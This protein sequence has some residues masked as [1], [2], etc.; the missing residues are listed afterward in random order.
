ME[1]TE[2]YMSGQHWQVLAN[3]IDGWNLSATEDRRL[4]H[5]SNRQNEVDVVLDADEVDSLR[6]ML[7][8][9]AA[10]TETTVDAAKEWLRD[11]A[12]DFAAQDR[13]KLYE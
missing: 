6:D 13:S 12:N 4:Y 9:I 8:Q 1:A 10:T 5:L 7:G 11:M 2:Y 3:E